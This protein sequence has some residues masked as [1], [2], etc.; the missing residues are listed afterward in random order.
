VKKADDA[1]LRDPGA[2]EEQGE[3]HQRK[4]EI[5]QH[6]EEAFDDGFD[7]L[8]GRFGQFFHSFVPSPPDFTGN[9]K[10]VIGNAKENVAVVAP[11]LR[12][13]PPSQRRAL[14]VRS[15]SRLNLYEPH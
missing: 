5:R 14:V 9:P 8:D 10:K 12:E 1:G 11:F 4:A 2:Q 3:G 15:N 6:P 13:R 7:L